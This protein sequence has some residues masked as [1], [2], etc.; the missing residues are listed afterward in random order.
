MRTQPLNASSAV[1]TRTHARTDTHACAF[2][3]VHVRLHARAHLY[4]MDVDDNG[5]IDLDELMTGMQ[6]YYRKFASNMLH[7][8]F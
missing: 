6:R 8:W 3:R 7:I 4:R 1:H 5:M 2:A